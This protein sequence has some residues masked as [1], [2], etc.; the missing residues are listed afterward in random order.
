M[1][2]LINPAAL[3]SANFVKYGKT[4]ETGMLSSN[5]GPKGGFT[6]GSKTKETPKSSDLIGREENVGHK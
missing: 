3:C 1:F 4:Q 5:R 2:I 6:L